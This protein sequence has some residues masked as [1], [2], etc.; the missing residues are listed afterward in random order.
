MSVSV[1]VCLSFPSF[2]PSI[3]LSFIPLNRASLC[4]PSFK[5]VI[6]SLPPKLGSCGLYHHFWHIIT[7]SLTVKYFSDNCYIATCQL[8][9]SSIIRIRNMTTFNNNLL[10]RLYN[11]RR[12]HNYVEN[13]VFLLKG[14]I[15][16]NYLTVHIRR[17]ETKSSE[18]KKSMTVKTDY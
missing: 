5:L 18:I 11:K 14:T 10:D 2:P 1:S 7:V 15:L 4:T 12:I 17:E 9:Y 3:C 8:V 6:L 16:N 13:I